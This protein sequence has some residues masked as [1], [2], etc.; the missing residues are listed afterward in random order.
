MEVL[1]YSFAIFFDD[2]NVN[3]LIKYI[4]FLLFL[5]LFINEFISLLCNKQEQ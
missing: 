5:L 4:L 2:I 1:K 3:V